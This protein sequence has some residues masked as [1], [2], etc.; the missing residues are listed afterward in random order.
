MFVCGGSTICWIV[1]CGVVIVRRKLRNSGGRHFANAPRLNPPKPPPPWPPPPPAPPPS[2]EPGAAPPVPPPAAPARPR[3]VPPPG[4]GRHELL[5][6]G[7]DL[8]LLGL[9]RLELHAPRDRQALSAR[10]QL[11][12]DLRNGA[13]SWCTPERTRPLETAETPAS[14]ESW[15]AWVCGNGSAGCRA[16]RSPGRSAIPASPASTGR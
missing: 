8:V 12:D 13:R 9:G 5:D 6:A 1:C 15:P 10:L 2:R 16:G 3:V 7:A 14:L 11:G 4:V